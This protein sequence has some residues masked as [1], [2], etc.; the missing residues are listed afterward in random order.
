M[1]IVQNEHENEDSQVRQE[2]PQEPECDL[3]ENE[4]KIIML[5][6]KAATQPGDM[7]ALVGEGM[8]RE[9]WYIRYMVVEMLGLQMVL[10][11]SNYT[12]DELQAWLVPFAL[13]DSNSYVRRA[14]VK[15][16]TD[17]PTLKM[18]ACHDEDPSVRAKAVEQLLRFLEN[19]G[20]ALGSSRKAAR[21]TAA[22]NKTPRAPK[23]PKAPKAAKEK[24]AEPQPEKTRQTRKKASSTRMAA[25]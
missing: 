7:E 10:N 20:F 22:P 6:N 5:L 19:G 13:H 16:L 1:A 18:A 4:R 17:L 14:A 23:A 21:K 15:N 12:P 3:K 2:R 25:N 9:E 24:E 8:E 11:T